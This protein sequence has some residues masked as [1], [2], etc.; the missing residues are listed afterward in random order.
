MVDMRILQVMVMLMPG[1]RMS[2]GIRIRLRHKD[3][4]GEGNV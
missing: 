2:M 1:A 4:V 3:R